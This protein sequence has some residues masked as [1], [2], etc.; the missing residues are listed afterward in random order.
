MHKILIDFI[1]PKDL[2]EGLLRQKQFMRAFTLNPVKYK[3]FDELLVKKNLKLLD[4]NSSESE[5]EPQVK[6]IKTRDLT[7]RFYVLKNLNTLTKTNNKIR[8]N[9]RSRSAPGI[10]HAADGFRQ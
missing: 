7:R 8:Q 9:A 6:D 1:N 10:H 2:K 4:I 3:D 5:D